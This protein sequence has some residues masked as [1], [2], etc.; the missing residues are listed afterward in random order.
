MRATLLPLPGRRSV[1]ILAV[2]ALLTLASL[3]LAATP[4]G[5]GYKGPTSQGKQVKFK[6]AGGRVVNPQFTIRSG[7]CTGTFY[8]YTSDAVNGRGR[9]SLSSGSTQF[10]GRFVTRRKATGTATAT[11]QGCPGGTKTVGYTARRR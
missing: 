1:A 9:F 2:A 7:P 10:R 11:F 6:V 4:R 8:M 5:G 3:A